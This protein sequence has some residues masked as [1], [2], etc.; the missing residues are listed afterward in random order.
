[1]YYMPENKKN[2]HSVPWH[3]EWAVKREGKKNPL[4]VHEK[5]AA[6]AKKTKTL[7]QK[8]QGEAVYHDKHGVIRDKDSYGNDPCPPKDKKH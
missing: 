6:A 1:M 2:F 7:S 8:S 4:S 5:Q 3:G